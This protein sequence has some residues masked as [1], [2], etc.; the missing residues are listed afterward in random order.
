M[1]QNRTR[2]ARVSRVRIAILD[3]YQRVA[4]QSAD[5]ASLGAT[6]V[7]PFHGHIADTADLAAELRPFDVVVAM[8][9]RTP[10]T[11][12]RL[13]LL[14]DLRLLVTTGMRNASIDVAA[15]AAAG[16]TVCGTGGSGAATP[17]LT[18]ALILAL[19]RHVPAEDRRM[20]D[21]GWQ[22]TIGFGLHGRTLG[23]VGLGNIGRRVASIG[24]AFGMEVLAW[25]QH[26]SATLA[27][28]AGAV[29]V[30]KEELFA[31]ADV[32]TVHYKLGKRSVGLVGERELGLMKPTA[33]LVNTSRGPIVDADA[34]LVALHSGAIAGA[35]L[36]VYDEE[37]LP[38]GHPLR[39]A[40]RTVLTPH[41][42]YVTDDGYRKF[43]G[44]AVEDIAA[45]AAGRP[46]RIIEPD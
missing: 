31:S 35:A 39:S 46:V 37:P 43:Y 1:G 28:D 32:I 25:S 24:R 13:R 8:R 30:S 17:E 14:P 5:W 9:E 21:G 41:L 15:A 27:A 45:F 16:V 4:L 23:V 44:D 10:F 3:D 42:G 6:E 19:V 33:F 12:D 22:H 40:P 34:L 26:L 29:A 36:D 18:W 20:R 38:P 11:A 7:V 2:T